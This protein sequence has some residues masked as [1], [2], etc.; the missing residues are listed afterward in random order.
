VA[1]KRWIA[2]HGLALNVS[3]DLDYF[4]LIKPCGITEYPVGSVESVLGRK[5]DFDKVADILADNFAALFGYDMEKVS[6]DKLLLE[7]VNE[8]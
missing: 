8:R 6:R 4:R 1:V 7:T 2:Y 3:T 5:V